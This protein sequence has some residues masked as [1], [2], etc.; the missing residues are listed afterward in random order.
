MKA[1]NKFDSKNARIKK[2]MYLCY[3]HAF[4]EY[5]PNTFFSENPAVKS[6]DERDD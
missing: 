5:F 4:Y 3:M 1:V 2:Y 6:E